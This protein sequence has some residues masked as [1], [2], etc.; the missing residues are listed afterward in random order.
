MMKKIFVL[1]FTIVLWLSVG[2]SFGQSYSLDEIEA[3]LMRGEQKALF[4]IAKY[5]DSKQKIH[6]IHGH[7]IIETTESQMAKMLLEE[8]C[9][10]THSEIGDYDKLTRKVFLY[11]LTKKK[12]NIVFSSLARAFFVTPLEARTSRIVCRE[13]TQSKKKELLEK[14]PI[15]VQM[16]WVKNAK[17]DSL[18]LK[19]NPIALLKI[20]SELYKA[21]YRFNS[22]FE[23]NKHQ[24]IELLQVL[25]GIQIA[26]EDGKKELNWHIDTLLFSEAS[27]NLLIYFAN[28]YT[29]FEWNPE[30][31]LF[32]NKELS[33]KPTDK[34]TNLFYLLGHKNDSTA[35]G[36][37]IELTTCNP[38]KVIQ[39]ADEFE[40][41]QIKEN[42]VLPG[43]PYRFLRQ[44]V[45]MTKYC[46]QHDIDFVGSKEL[47]LAIRRLDSDLS[48][49]DRRK[50]EDSL[51][52]HLQLEQI[53][54][55]E[56]WAIIYEKSWELTYSSGRIL[57]IFYS[58]NWHKL[59]HDEKHLSLFLKKS[60]FLRGLYIIG[61]C[62]NYLNKF[63][64]LG[65]L[66][67]ERLEAI[68]TKDVHIKE[69]AKMAK[70]FCD[71]PLEIPHDKNKF[72]DTN[73]NHTISDITQK[74]E[75]I[76]KITDQETMENKLI[77]LLSQISY[78]QIGEA[79]NAIEDIDFKE[80]ERGKYSFMERDW[81][82][83]IE[84][85]FNELQARTHFLELYHQFSE[86]ELYAY[87]LHKAGIHYKNNDNS[88]DYDKIFEILKYNVV[89]AFVGGGGGKN[90]NEVYAII[91][92]LELTHNTTLGY[93]EK[94]CNSK[95]IYA[96]NSQDRANEW[97][98]FL[99]AQKLLKYPHN[100][101]PSFNQEQK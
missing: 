27:L 70:M 79:L 37:F 17:I 34:E 33:I 20:A 13:I 66:G 40:N 15:L 65:S 12:H 28:N 73:R 83:F 88:L 92:I 38:E 4:K 7:K 46:K 24:Y 94:I 25:T 21:R 86:Y 59:L 82:F 19:N 85:N 1:T 36:A 9:L 57:D 50:L 39:L 30:I 63:V 100:E 77:E 43:F 41:A 23:N 78:A 67:K 45:L 95:D 48:F 55:F 60:F 53:T 11:F 72:N 84:D 56:Y 90:D 58:K 8:N 89:V 96:C 47:Q 26:V 93:P 10:F 49:V 2:V 22:D 18:I 75:L 62:N 81:G 35:L 71:R 14:Y 16:K 87:Y 97:M 54:A 99:I 101:P 51:I 61:M 6:I 52:H 42:Y 44:L 68:T 64:G 74:I 3:M 29:K 76:K 98:R 69:E 5:L 32:V 91:K 80:N 31:S